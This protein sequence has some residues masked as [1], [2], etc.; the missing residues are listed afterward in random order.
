MS[1]PLPASTRPLWVLLVLSTAAWAQQPAAPT[2]APTT[3]VTAPTTTPAPTLTPPA[4]TPASPKPFVTSAFAYGARR[5]WFN[6]TRLLGGGLYYQGGLTQGLGGYVRA[7]GVAPFS[8]SGVRLVER[9]GFIS[10]ALVKVVGF[11]LMIFGA[12][13]S[14]SANSTTTY[15]GYYTDGGRTFVVEKETISVNSS[16]AAAFQSDVSSMQSAVDAIGPGQ[17]EATNDFGSGLWA[18]FTLFDPHLAL[19]NREAPGA[20][21]YDLAFGTDLKVGTLF[22]LPLVLDL[23]LAMAS[24]RAPRLDS[25]A[26]ST[27]LYDCFGVMARLHVPLSKFV[28]FSVD[29]TLNFYALGYLT[30]P[31]AL[32]AD[33]RVVSMPL[34]AN[35][36]LHLTD[37][38]FARGSAVLG[39][40]GLTDGKLGLGV[41]V[42]VRL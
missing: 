36:E 5:A 4:V 31:E 40:I 27:Y 39:G 41:D 23:G 9:H 11:T 24:I 20:T 32:T 14:A 13:A 33:G 15:E 6:G 30:A 35:L 28:T 17:V 7:D 19:F 37:R 18:D 12:V 3:A 29:W 34:R 25:A 42:G 22:G 10:T 26:H 2:D 21:G 1:L 8:M 38:F 16:Q